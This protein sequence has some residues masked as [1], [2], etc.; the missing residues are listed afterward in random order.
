PFAGGLIESARLLPYAITAM[1]LEDGQ[2]VAAEE[3]EALSSFVRFSGSDPG[4]WT[5]AAD[6]ITELPGFAVELYT[7]A[8]I[9]SAVK[10]GGMKVLKEALLRAATKEGR[11]QLA[12]VMVR[13]SAKNAVGAWAKNHAAKNVAF[14]I[15]SGLI[16]EAARLPVAS[17][18][19]ILAKFTEDTALQGLELSPQEG[20]LVLGVN[21]QARKGTLHR[22]ADAIVDSYIENLSERSG[23]Y[24]VGGL[25]KAA[26]AVPFTRAVRDSLANM[27]NAAKGKL[28]SAALI[29]SLVAKNPGVPLTKLQAFLKQANIGGVLEE[30]GEERVGSVARD[31]WTGLSTGKWDLTIPTTEDLALE[32]LTLLVPGAANTIS[33]HRHFSKLDSALRSSD[34][35]STERLEGLANDPHAHAERLGK[36]VGSSIAPEELEAARALVG[37]VQAD[38]M[39]RGID[40]T[41]VDLMER[42]E[43]ALAAGDLE[44]ASRLKQM[45]LLQ[46]RSRST[47]ADAAVIRGVQTAR[48]IDHLRTQ[49]AEMRAQAEQL[50]ATDPVSADAMAIQAEQMEQ[51]AHRAAAIVKTARGRE[52]TLTVA[53]SAAL[54]T[55][56]QPAV[57]DEGG[58]LIITDSAREELSSIAPT[59]ARYV[60]QSESMRREQISA[61]RTAASAAAT[62]RGPTPADTATAPR[63]PS[64][65]AVG[66]PTAS[67]V[68][69]AQ[70]AV[71]A[72]PAAAA[73]AAGSQ[74]GVGLWTGKGT[75]GTRLSLPAAEARSPQ[76]AMEK[77]AAQLPQDEDFDGASLMPPPRA[78]SSAPAAASSSASRAPAAQASNVDV[79][80]TAADS[81][82]RA[83]LPRAAHAKAKHVLDELEKQLRQYGGFFARIERRRDL[84]GSGLELRP[85]TRDLL[86]DVPAFIRNVG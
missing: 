21:A 33:T 60:K 26:G 11:K 27:G 30:M 81:D 54:Q 47:A 12:E 19:R 75:K 1:K 25:S 61:A 22:V 46:S 76:Q 62:P 86:V 18:G 43:S 9:A 23:A 57:V 17:S 48:E 24:M 55:A 66:T 84:S 83:S 79:W 14:R 70:G 68:D 53:E 50:A 59:A 5:K 41:Q 20:R 78:S 45:A 2:E 80:R 8:G 64:A 16:Q 10:A 15:G 4:F 39:L 65:Q 34:A 29:K 49:A 71:A 51:A 85:S 72:P 7:T 40:R 44:K 67:G 32:F 28:L 77:M 52:A 82:V 37:P 42:A 3:L 73:P 31:V 38:D 35:E 56:A 69:T 36:L 6:G 63:G 74:S 58:A 13:S